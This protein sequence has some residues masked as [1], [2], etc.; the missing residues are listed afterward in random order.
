MKL[1]QNLMDQINRIERD[2]ENLHYKV[3]KIE[4]L[5]TKV[6]QKL[7]S[8]CHAIGFFTFIVVVVFFIW[9]YS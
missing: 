5:L 1:N 7:S 9:L 3:N 6:D 2:T 8:L 4:I